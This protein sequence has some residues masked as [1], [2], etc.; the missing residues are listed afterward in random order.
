MASN[1]QILSD[2]RLIMEAG[3]LLELLTV[4]KGVPFICKA[5][6]N[7]I[8][9]DN[10]QVQALDPAMV[11]MLNAKQVR[12]LGSDYFEPSVAQISSFDILTGI[13]DLT[14]LT[15][16]GTK[17]G[18]RMIVRVEPKS[19]LEVIIQTGGQKTAGQLADLSI[20]GVGMRVG[21]AAYNPTLKPGTTIQVR[22]QLPNGDISLS[23]TLLSA[24]K[25]DEFYRL[26]MRFTQNGPKKTVVFKY[27]VDRRS[28][29][30]AELK[31]EYEKA[32]HAKG[33][34]AK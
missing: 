7:A 33:E 20:N 21:H 3:H 5:R 32:L 2:L 6:I 26:S 22:M 23:G 24:V 19:P 15:F 31:Q 18:E 10:V 9:G 13:A 28:E 8:E 34:A 1:Q 17:L 27:L 14:D 29:I 4:Y 11:C 16:L 12:L 30:E 25:M